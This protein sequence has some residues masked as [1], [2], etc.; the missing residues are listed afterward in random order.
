MIETVSKARTAAV[1]GTAAV[2][3]DE[4]GGS[5]TTG[6]LRDGQTWDDYAPYG[7][8]GAEG[9]CMH[10]TA[11]VPGPLLMSMGWGSMM[12]RTQAEPLLFKRRE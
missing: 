11:C 1:Q 12:G 4:P 6:S 7:V 2:G 5:T 10:L 8:A 3:A 9:C